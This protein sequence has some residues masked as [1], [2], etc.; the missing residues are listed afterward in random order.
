M[1]IFIFSFILT[2]FNIQNTYGQIS[3]TKLADKVIS[4]FSGTI[5]SDSAQYPISWVVAPL[6]AYS[7]ETNLQLGLGSVWVFKTKNALPE[8]RSSNAF[9]AARYTLNQQVTAAPSYTIFTK[10]EKYNHR[11]EISFRKFPQFYYGIGNRTPASNEELYGINT[12]SVEHITYRNVIDKLYAGAG[13]RYLRSY[14][15]VFK[16]GGLLD[17][18]RPDRKSVV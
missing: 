7:P 8:D 6:V 10:G 18:N 12:I 11:G 17:T 5:R 16:E 3:V 14:D 1:R 2:V 9:F 13:I 15:L 4:A